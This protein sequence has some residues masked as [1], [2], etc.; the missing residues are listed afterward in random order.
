[1]RNY[2]HLQRNPPPNVGSNHVTEF[3]Q[4]TDGQTCTSSYEYNLAGALT[5]E[6][7]PLGRVVENEFDH[8]G[9][10][11]KIFGKATTTST[12]RV[13]ASNFAYSPD[14]KIERLKLGSGVWESAK[15]N[16][17]LQVKE[18]SVGWGPSSSSI[19]K[20]TTEFGELQTNGT[21][22]AT[23]NNGNIGKQTVSFT[24]LAN[25][26]VQTYKYDM[27]YR[28][29]EAKESNNSNQTWK[30]VFEYDRYGNRTGHDKFI[31]TTEV[32]QAE[33]THP[34]I[35]PASNRFVDEQGYTFD[36]N[37][38][39]VVD[40]E[41]RQFTFNGDNKQAEVSYQ[42][43]VVN[44]SPAVW[45][46][47][48]DQKVKTAEAKRFASAVYVLTNDHLTTRISPTDQFAKGLVYRFRGRKGH[49]NIFIKQD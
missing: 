11:A 25:P 17:R 22:D 3:K 34:A 24:G 10:L 6:T 31:G 35:D 18:L 28:L 30:Q 26:F 40:A 46:F 41:G 33:E 14:G 5:K 37:G 9:D 21:V 4:F 7:Y 49:R 12:E 19:W 47:P 16:S 15:F 13:Y 39:I 36:E 8:N 42:W 29:T 32:T 45:V 2:G 27:L 38:N 23:Q 44:A 1:M 43:S 20:M 48:V